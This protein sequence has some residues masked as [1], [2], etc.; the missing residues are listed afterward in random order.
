MI[1][2]LSQRD[3]GPRNGT[4]PTSSWDKD[5]IIPDVYALTIPRDAKPGEYQLIIGMYAWPDLQ[6]LPITVVSTGQAMDHYRLP[7]LLHVESN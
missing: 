2:S 6:R 3:A 5:E 7:T 4:Y 1:S